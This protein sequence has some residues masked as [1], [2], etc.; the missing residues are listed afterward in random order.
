MSKALQS[1]E[2]TEYEQ[3]LSKITGDNICITSG[4]ANAVLGALCSDSGNFDVFKETSQ[5]GLRQ[6]QRW[7][8]NLHFQEKDSPKI[9]NFE[10]KIVRK[11]AF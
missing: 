4:K 11:S 9:C 5:S 6:V 7:S 8:E 3:L 2:V 10:K 1:K